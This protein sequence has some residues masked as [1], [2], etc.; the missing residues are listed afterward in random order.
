MITSRDMPKVLVLDGSRTSPD[1]II[2]GMFCQMLAGKD[3]KHVM[4]ASCRCYRTEKSPNPPK[5]PWRVLGKTAGGGCWEQCRFFCFSKASSVPAVPPGT[6][7]ST[8]HGTFGNV[9]FLS[10]VTAVIPRARHK[11]NDDS[12]T[13]LDRTW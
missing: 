12:R 5:V 7:P 4:D 10:P 1:V 2:L 8:L 11:R 3:H 13:E 6:L 9:G